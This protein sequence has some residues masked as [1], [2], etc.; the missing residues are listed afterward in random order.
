MTISVLSITVLRMILGGILLFAGIAKLGSFSSFVSHLDSYQMLPTALVQP[1]SYL[2]VST[3]I[4]LG[5]TLCL[6]YFS[7]G[8]GILASLLFFIFATALIK[9]LLQK[10]PVT[11][12]GCENFLF[13]ALKLL[14]LSVSTMPN[15]TMVFADVG[16]GIASFGIACSPQQGYGLELLIQRR[17]HHET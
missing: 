16:L 10:L 2:L 3:E 6:G 13:S 8:A 15:W 17:Q 5:I 11:D 7:A 14:G 1:V 4:T 12:C 9:V